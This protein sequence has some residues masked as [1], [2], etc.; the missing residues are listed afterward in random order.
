MDSEK[1]FKSLKKNMEKKDDIK[2]DSENMGNSFNEMYK[3]FKSLTLEFTIKDKKIKQVDLKAKI[4]D[5]NPGL[6]KA[7]LNFSFKYNKISNIGE[8]AFPKDLKDYKMV[9][10]TGGQSPSPLGL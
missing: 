9:N 6:G 7:T 3:S 8:I 2:A 4:K 5:K 10:N 1:F